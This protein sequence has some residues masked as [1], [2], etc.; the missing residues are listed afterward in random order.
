MRDSEGKPYAGPL[1][2][3]VISADGADR[4]ELKGWSG[5]VASA[6]LLERFFTPDSFLSS[7]LVLATKGMSLY[8]DAVYRDKAAD[9]LKAAKGLEGAAKD[10]K[11]DQYEA[12]LKNIQDDDIRDSVKRK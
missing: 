1:P 8:N 3:V 10:A 9:A 4:P 6:A 12:Y 2:Y 7:S 11:M 5:Q